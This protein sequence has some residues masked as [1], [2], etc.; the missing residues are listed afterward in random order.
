MLLARI[1]IRQCRSFGGLMIGGI[2]DGRRSRCRGCSRGFASQL[3]SQGRFSFC[4]SLLEP[5]FDGSAQS[6][7]RLAVLRIYWL[8]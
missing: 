1:G 4:A 2:R 7:I 8:V 5:D 6:L 3:P